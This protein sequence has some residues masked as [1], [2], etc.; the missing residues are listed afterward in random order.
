V[1]AEKKG[2]GWQNVFDIVSGTIEP[3]VEDRAFYDWLLVAEPDN[4]L[5][6][7]NVPPEIYFDD[8]SCS[9]LSLS[10]TVY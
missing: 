6:Q 1:G 4:A 2:T 7:M 3:P 10:F 9:H 8:L 5:D